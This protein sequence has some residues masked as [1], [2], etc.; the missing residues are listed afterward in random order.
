MARECS[1]Y[2]ARLMFSI[3]CKNWSEAQRRPD[4]GIRYT[5][6]NFF[7]F[8][9]KLSWATGRRHE[10]G[11]LAVKLNVFLIF[12]KEMFSIFGKRMFSIFG[13]VNVL[14]VL[15]KLV[16]GPMAE[17]AIQILIFFFFR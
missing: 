17:S 4:G 2:L 11:E 10:V 5:N 16:R 14:N 9:I 12:G 7:I 6:I 13:K 15:Q 3:F 1:Q 8:Q